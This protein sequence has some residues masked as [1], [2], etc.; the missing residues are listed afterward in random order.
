MRFVTIVNRLSRPVKCTWEGRHMEFAPGKHSVPEQVALAARQQNPIYGTEVDGPYMPD[1][2]HYVGIPD[3]PYFDPVDSISESQEKELFNLQALRGA[4][5]VKLVD[6]IQ[7]VPGFR[8]IQAQS[9]P[10]IS[11]GPTTSGFVDPTK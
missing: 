1:F 4:I 6:N 2:Q 9:S 5:P 10:L 3:A 11:G 8:S 7:L